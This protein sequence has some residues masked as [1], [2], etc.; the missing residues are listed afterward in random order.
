MKHIEAHVVT[1]PHDALALYEAG[2]PD[3]NGAST[4]ANCAEPLNAQYTLLLDEH[5]H[6]YLCPDCS[7]P[8][9]APG[10]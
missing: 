3:P 6:W 10:S 2:M 7:K 8:L 9:T 5:D 4:C 1:S